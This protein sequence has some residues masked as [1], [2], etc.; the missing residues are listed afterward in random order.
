MITF[1]QY[2]NEGTWA[3]FLIPENEPKPVRQQCA[4]LWLAGKM[5]L[6]AKGLQGACRALAGCLHDLCMLLAYVV[7]ETSTMFLAFCHAQNQHKLPMDLHYLASRPALR[8]LRL[9][10]FASRPAL[11]ELRFA[12]FAPR[13]SLR[14]RRFANFASRT[15]LTSL[16]DLRTSLRE[17]CFATFASRPSLRDLRFASLTSRTSLREFRFANFASRPSL[18]DLCFANFAYFASRPSLR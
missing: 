3:D 14:D 15:S 6:L 13:P 4:I 17:L 2:Y 8:E 16:R 10:N 12:H 5:Y 7:A 9:A 1:Y 11:R 18:R